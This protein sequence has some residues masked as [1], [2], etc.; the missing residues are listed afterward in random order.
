MPVNT[1]VCPECIPA[2]LERL[3]GSCLLPPTHGELTTRC[4][5]RQKQQYGLFSN[6]SSSNNSGVNERQVI[7]DAQHTHTGTHRHT[8]A[9]AL[10]G[11]FAFSPLSSSSSSSGQAS[12]ASVRL[13]GSC[14][15]TSL[16]TG[17]TGR[18]S[19]SHWAGELATEDFDLTSTNIAEGE[20]GNCSCDCV[21]RCCCPAL[22]ARD[23]QDPHRRLTDGPTRVGWV[24]PLVLRMKGATAAAVEAL[25]FDGRPERAD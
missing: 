16:S 21:G 3:P 20:S 8:Q 14:W 24:A 4:S 5:S 18:P 17:T 6:G 13:E 23:V 12:S 11:C 25:L 22:A 15:L 9:Q 19:S 7:Q 2:L 10:A 1:P